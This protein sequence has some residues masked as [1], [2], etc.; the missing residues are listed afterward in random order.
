[1]A[2]DNS[3]NQENQR[4]DIDLDDI[5]VSILVIAKAPNNLTQ[6]A[7]FLTR[8]GWPTTVIGSVSQS[9]EFIAEKKP[10]FVLV[11][12][13]HTNPAMA[14]VPD[15]IQ[16]TFNLT[17]IAFI[18]TMDSSSQAKL[19]KSKLRYK[20]AGQPSGPTLH[21]SIRKILAEKLNL[22][23]EERSSGESS[24][25]SAR[26]AD[27]TVTIRGSNTAA[28]GGTI[29]QKSS[30]GPAQTGAAYVPT[31][32]ASQSGSSSST[33]NGMVTGSGAVVQSSGPV[34]ATGAI[35]QNSSADATRGQG[36]IV[37]KGQAPTE[38][39][40]TQSGQEVLKTGKYTMTKANRRSL[41]ELTKSEEPA[42]NDAEAA[43]RQAELVGMLKK[44][45]LGDKKEEELDQAPEA[46][47][48]DAEF[49]PVS[50]FGTG[51]KG[52]ISDPSRMPLEKIVEDALIGL[53]TPAEVHTTLGA[54]VRVGVFP[55]D[56]PVTP[57]YLVIATPMAERTR[58]QLFKDAEKALMHAFQA[59]G[60]PGKLEAGFWVSIPEVDFVEWSQQGAKFSVFLNHEGIE[61][62]AAFFQSSEALPKIEESSSDGMVS[63]GVGH[64][65]TEVPVTFK[66]YLHLNKND[67][68][69][70]YIRNG[71]K[72]QAEQKERLKEHNVSNFHMKSVDKENIR[73]FLA[74]S[75]LSDS[76]RIKRSGGAAA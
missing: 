43:K 48:Q 59:S 76:I 31:Q 67:K 52:Q 5:E 4:Q 29:I 57:G 18:E 2:Q 11:S 63:L 47:T 16:G 71:R 55:V 74:A 44:S 32:G 41:K 24:N 70:L 42:V 36:A 21:R 27:S 9:I 23:S 25:D 30:V 17:C 8:R 38:A 45:L 19:A 1:V 61:L 75:F 54:T 56:S 69:Y 6:M 22:N 46:E 7:S 14:K 40:A 60:A 26:S 65:S 28:D 53:C 3:A 64:V 34:T 50:Y 12:L 72:L 20:I 37:D 15:L 49:C 58:A 33:S 13:N 73:M 35:V 62:C 66:A 10:D 39:N 68:F 51:E